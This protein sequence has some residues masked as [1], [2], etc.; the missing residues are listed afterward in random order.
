VTAA[1]IE[2]AIASIEDSTDP[3]TI[4]FELVDQNRDSVHAAQVKSGGP[5][6]E[7]SAPHAFGI[8]L[9]MIR[10]RPRAESYRLVTNMRLHPNAVQ[11]NRALNI[12]DPHEL[13]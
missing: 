1:L 9:R 2:P 13:R 10:A 11:L 6:T 7:M 3:D 4:D 5:G 8:L 12:D